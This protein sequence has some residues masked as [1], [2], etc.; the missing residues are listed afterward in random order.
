MKKREKIDKDASQFV[1]IIIES[2]CNFQSQKC[3]NRVELIR[4]CFE[5]NEEATLFVNIESTAS[6]MLGQRQPII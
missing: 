2:N 5:C 3:K 1:E 4:S 6:I